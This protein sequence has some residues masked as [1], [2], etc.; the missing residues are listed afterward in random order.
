LYNFQTCKQ[1]VKK[2]LWH[3]IFDL[4]FFFSSSNNFPYAPDTRLKLFWIWLQIRDIRLWNRR[5]C[6]Q[7]CQWHRS[8]MHS[9]FSFV[10]FVQQ[11]HWHSCTE[12]LW[13][14]CARGPNIWSALA[15]FK[16]N[17][18]RKN[19][20]K[21]GKLIYTLCITFTQKNMGVN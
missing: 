5:F 9:G 11:C 14:R 17:A 18:Y 7:R 1:F 21:K 15:T 20:H 12:Q 3:Q 16:G 10:N 6:S 8:V 19:I 13:H 2:K 4:W